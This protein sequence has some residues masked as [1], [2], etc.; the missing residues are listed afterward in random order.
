MR[1]AFDGKGLVERSTTRTAGH[2][3][4]GPGRRRRPRRCRPC[5][6]SARSDG[7][8]AISLSEWNRVTRFPT[9][10]TVPVRSVPMTRILGFVNPFSS[11]TIIAPLR[12]IQSPKH[13][14][15]EWMRTDHR[16]HAKR[17]AHAR[18]EFQSGHSRDRPSS[19]YAVDRRTHRASCER[20]IVDRETRRPFILDALHHQR[21]KWRLANARPEPDLSSHG[22]L[23]A[24]CG[25][26]PALC[27]S[28]R[29]RT[30]DVAPT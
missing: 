2:S 1:L 3:P 17:Y 9:D 14:E 15:D 10:S 6:R 27:H 28:S 23:F 11:R 25:H 20:P 24:V 5:D 21:S 26:R 22:L 18:T 13:T 30:S 12:M 4:T 29:E 8:S 19:V 16:H 7:L